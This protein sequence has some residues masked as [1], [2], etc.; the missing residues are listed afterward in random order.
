MS[1]AIE[2]RRAQ[3]EL[4]FDVTEDLL[5][6]ME[7]AGITKAELARLMNKSKSRIS[8][9]LTGE[10]N[11]TL[12]TLATMCFEIGTKIDVRIGDEFSVRDPMS[13]PNRQEREEFD[14]A[15]AV[16]SEPFKRPR[17]RLVC[18]NDKPEITPEPQ[19]SDC[20][21]AGVAL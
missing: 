18:S 11:M 3:D 2:R 14:E 20:W 19:W 10:A 9:M 8:Q 21:E 12:R 13:D 6:A 17:M 5:I 4:I 7:D 15:H 16:E 1:K